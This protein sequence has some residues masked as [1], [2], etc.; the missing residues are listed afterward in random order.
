MQFKYKI[1]AAFVI[2]VLLIGAVYTIQ[3]VYLNR[4]V[5]TGQGE[6]RLDETF[7]EKDFTYGL[8]AWAP[9]ASKMPLIPD[10]NVDG[11]EG[12]Y[13]MFVD[14]N[15][16]SNLNSTFPRVKVDYAFSGLHGTAAFHVYG[17]IHSGGSVSWTNRVEGS[18]ASGY[19]V[20]T[21]QQ[22]TSNLA[23]KQVMEDFNHLYVKV[24]NSAGATF[25]ANGDNTYLMRFEKVGGGLNTLHITTEPQVPTGQV[26]NTNN[27]AGTFYLTFTGDRIQDTFIL[28]VAING[29]IGEDFGL[30]LKASVPQ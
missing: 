16:T 18:G 14:L 25:N 24:A 12:F 5:S 7:T 10:A 3:H 13:L 30:N 27:S 6:Y 29:S 21:D 22:P 28:L 23:G 15:A 1:A 17:Y 8:Q 26:T 19:Y 11:G 4:E 2:F 9:Y 20:T